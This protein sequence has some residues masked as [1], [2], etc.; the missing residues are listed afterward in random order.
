MWGADQMRVSS[1]NIITSVRALP[2]SGDSED[3][4]AEKLELFL[5]HTYDAWGVAPEAARG[6][7]WGR[8]DPG[9]TLWFRVVRR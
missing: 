8:Q 7:W 3:E 2:I 1:N 9:Q 4:T 6:R 5:A